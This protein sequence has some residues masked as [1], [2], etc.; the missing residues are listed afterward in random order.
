MVNNSKDNQDPKILTQ[1]KHSIEINFYFFNQK[2]N[3]L[4]LYIIYLSITQ[5]NL[6]FDFINKI[7][8]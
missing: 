6:T 2:S 3:K 7:D 1:I 4:K 8:N 5:I